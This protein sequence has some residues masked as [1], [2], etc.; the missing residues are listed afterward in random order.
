MAGKTEILLKLSPPKILT[1]QPGNDYFVAGLC[2]HALEECNLFVKHGRHL[3][4]YTKCS[5]Y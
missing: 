4:N 5:S 3:E 2:K 1:F